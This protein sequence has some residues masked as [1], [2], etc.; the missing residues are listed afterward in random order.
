MNTATFRGKTFNIL[1]GA[2]HKAYSLAIFSEGGEEHDFR[3]KYWTV[4]PGEVVVDVGAS[5]GAYTL[6]ALAAGAAKVWA[7]EPEPS[8]LVDLQRNLD[9]NDWGRLRCS[10]FGAALWDVSGEQVHMGDWAPHWPA[11]TITGRYPTATLDEL[12]LM[13]TLSETRLDWCKIDV[14]GAEAHVLRGAAET[15]RRFKPTIIL[16][17]HTFL[18]ATLLDR[19]VALLKGYGYDGFEF[20]EREP[21]VMVIAKEL[22]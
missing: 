7:F 21:C 13:P 9:A 11:Q 5:Y 6:T 15:L 3:E 2:V 12:M 20:V 17:V 14:E 19:C 8:V 18:D 22:K 4:Q 10:A 1:E 16:E